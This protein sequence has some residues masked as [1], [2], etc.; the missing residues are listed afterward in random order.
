MEICVALETELG[1]QFAIRHEGRC[2]KADFYMK[3]VDGAGVE[4]AIII[5]IDGQQHFGPWYFERPGETY[6][7]RMG[8]DLCKMRWAFGADV[9]IVRIPVSMLKSDPDW[10]YATRALIASAMA[11]RRGHEV[12]GSRVPLFLYPG[13]G[14]MYAEHVRPWRKKDL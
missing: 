4:R 5:E 3:F 14:A 2:L 7:V 6:D 12:D 13:S 9:P 1:Y 10:K 11:W 8:R